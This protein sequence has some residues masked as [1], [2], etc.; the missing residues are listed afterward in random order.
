[1]KNPPKIYLQ[2]LGCDGITWDPKKLNDDDIEYTRSDIVEQLVE[3]A[4]GWLRVW[5]DEAAEIEDSLAAID[6]LKEALAQYH[7]E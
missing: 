2:D 4:E 1:M 7:N 3:A 5:D 6:F